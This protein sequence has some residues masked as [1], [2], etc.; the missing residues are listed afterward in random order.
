MY[1]IFPLIFAAIIRG[2]DQV[3]IIGDDFMAK[4]FAQ[5]FQ[6][7]YSQDGKIGYIRAH[8]DVTGYCQSASRAL[9]ENI[10]SRIRNALVTAINSELLFPKAII[11]VLEND[12]LNAAD[13]YNPGI[14]LICSK[15]LDWLA[16][17]IH[18]IVITHKEK[19]P[20][21]ACKFKYP[22]I[23][24]FPLPTHQ[25][26]NNINEARGKFN[27]ALRHSCSLHRKMELLPLNG[28]AVNDTSL[29]SKNG[30]YTSRGFATFWQI[31]NEAF[32]LWDKEQM[33]L[34]HL[35]SPA[36]GDQK[37]N[38]HRERAALQRKFVWK[39]QFTKFKLPKPKFS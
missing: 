19:L 12:I 37:S 7:A 3:W 17:Q 27:A 39:P 15:V 32:Q 26:L 29:T 16:N 31:V 33:R 25:N 4:S 1:N 30:K 34:S 23:L 35:P 2:Y 5:Y 6:D 11:M 38:F 9:N 8:Y 20:S 13:H 21:K 14:S 10:L 24:W 28:W 36:R 18:R 22:K